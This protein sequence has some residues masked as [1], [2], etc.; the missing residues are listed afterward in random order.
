MMWKKMDMMTRLS[1]NPETPPQRNQD[2]TDEIGRIEEA[3]KRQ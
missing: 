2:A 3:V 1:P